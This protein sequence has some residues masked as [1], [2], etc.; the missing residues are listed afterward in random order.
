MIHHETSKIGNIQV[1]ERLSSQKAASAFLAVVL[2]VYLLA[3]VSLNVVLPLGEAPDEPAH[4]A[5]VRYVARNAA[6]PV[7][8]P[9]YEDNETVEG[10]QAPLYYVLAA[11]ITFPAMGQ[12]VDLHLNPAFSF[13]APEPGVP[14]FLPLAEHRFPWRG[15]YLAWHLTRLFSLGLGAVS[16]W[17]TYRAGLLAFGKRWLAVAAVA[18]L[19][20]NPQFIYVHSAVT[21]DT[22][23]T[24]A[25]SLI[26]LMALLLLRVSASWSFGT[27]AM[28]IALA[29]L[30]KPSAL[31]LC[32]GLAFALWKAWRALPSRRARWLSLGLLIAVPAASSGWW[33]WRNRQLYGDWMGLS[34]AK[35]ALSAN[36]YPAPLSVRQLIDLLPRI[37]RQTFKTSWGVFGWISMPLPDWAFYGILSVHLIA[38]VGLFVRP[39]VLLRRWATALVLAGSWL[40]LIAGFL[41]Y[42]LE[43]NASGWHGRFLFP[44]LSAMALGVV[45][46]WCNWFARREALPAIAIAVSQGALVVFAL[47]QVL[48][49][50]YLPPPTL[51][52]DAALPNPLEV[53]FAGGLRLVGYEQSPSKVRAGGTAEVTLYWQ[54]Q[55]EVSKAYRHVLAARTPNGEPLL[56]KTECPLPLRSPATL[57]PEMADDNYN[58]PLMTIRNAH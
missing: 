38:A 18:Y 34:M 42:N 2:V 19:A 22:L 54:V 49:P 52:L 5:Y 44:G 14:T 39:R 48:L 43:T 10:F 57:W 12:E 30:S 27:A 50:A 15:S 45:A 58:Y 55:G 3:G 31:T 28:A 1:R 47:T 26:T 29:A 37:L 46:G 9:R 21:N 24:T 13:S 51:P 16:L 32:P 25:G 35:Q 36:Y 41:Y 40:G 6:L 56:P 4:F 20:L 11:A 23:A 53:D 17:A 7:M 8:Q 33:F